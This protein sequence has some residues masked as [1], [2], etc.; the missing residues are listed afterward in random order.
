MFITFE[1]PEGGGKT[2]QLQ[3]LAST[4]RERGYEVVVTREPGGTSV[5]DVI[6]QLL[7][8]PD[9]DG[10][11]GARAEALLFAAARAQLVEEIIRPALARGA[12]VL[13]DRFGD[14]TLAYQ[15]GGRRLPER[16]IRDI[17]TFATGGLTP[18]L[19][20]LLDLDIEDGRRRKAR[21]VADRLEREDPAFHERVR[22]A[23]LELASR[24]P[25][26]FVLIDASQS[27]DEVARQIAQR[28]EL[29]MRRNG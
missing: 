2:T 7:L 3:R 21:Q 25:D 6:R 14:S 8:T 13:S 27:V 4:L 19:T 26:R 24:E 18:D 10:P 29:A 20:F 9:A 5:G 11:V 15:V 1:G 12:I 17:I 16:E 22:A 23:Y 28:V